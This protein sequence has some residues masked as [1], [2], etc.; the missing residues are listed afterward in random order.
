LSGIF[1]HKFGT[2]LEVA[3]LYTLQ[4]AAEVLRCSQESN[5]EFCIL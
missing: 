5:R 1:Y 4:N 2:T 3:V